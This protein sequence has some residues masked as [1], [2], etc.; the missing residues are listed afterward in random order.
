MNTAIKIICA[1][2]SMFMICSCDE[3][4]INEIVA[5]P[6]TVE[7]FEPVEGYA[8]CEVTLIGQSLND[9]V[10]ASIG[11]VKADIVQRITENSLIIRVPSLAQSGKIEVVNSKG[12]G[13]SANEFIVTYPCPEPD[14]SRIPEN[15]ELSSNL[16]ISGKRMSVINRVLFSS[17]GY[18]NH[19]AEIIEQIDHEI[20]VKAPFVESELATIAFEYFD[21]KNLVVDNNNTVKIKVDRKSPVVSEISCTEGFVGDEVILNGKNLDKV[22]R[23]LIDNI[24]CAIAVQSSDVLKFVIPEIEDLSGDIN[25]C[26]LEIEY[27]GGIERIVIE[28]S[29]IIKLQP[30]LFWQDV[31]LWCQGRDVEELTSFFSPQT[32]IAYSNSTWRQLDP[33]SY[34][35]QAA[36]C[37]ASQVPAVSKDEYDA[38]VPYFFFSGVNAGNMQINSPAGSASQL[39]NF[40]ME[41]NS[42]NEYR[43][44]GS[45]GNCYGTPVVGFVV[46]DRENSADAAL[47]ER[48][49]TGTLSKLDPATFPIDTE[50]LT[51]GDISISSISNSP[52]DT[53][54]A[55][56]VFTVGQNLDTD[57][58]CYIMVLYYNHKGID[59]S[60]KSLN[61]R[62]MGILHIKH[63]DFRLY[64]N[65]SAPSSSSI[66]FDM[67]WM[68]K[69]YDN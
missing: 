57:V 23:V 52:K 47:I 4:K 62:R 25:T 19:E 40:Y 12:N 42:A 56:G 41:N 15:I 36:T 8:G 18:D 26:S 34:Q 64:N 68:A 5:T 55:P 17:E 69:D 66:L 14:F 37:S 11:G 33:I 59:S 24:E 27:F 31:K 13:L 30:F 29:F 63:I 1:L 32:G 44:T 46:L 50:S 60:N 58:D 6:P 49:Q 28:S 48:I 38:V 39:K 16:L 3:V 65:T 7:S 21:G 10:E 51:C 9:V 53:A 61:I 35:Y 22:D 43:V 20:I 2:I 45:S 54:F 67:Y